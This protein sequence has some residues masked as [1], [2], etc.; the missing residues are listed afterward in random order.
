MNK[1]V[2]LSLIACAAACAG[3]TGDVTPAT[4]EQV[5]EAVAQAEFVRVVLASSLAAANLPPAFAD[6]GNAVLTEADAALDKCEEQVR[7]T[8]V[9]WVYKVCTTTVLK[10][11]RF[12][13]KQLQREAALAT[14]ST[15]SP[16]VAN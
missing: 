4:P 1:F 15:G 12:Q 13:L 14:A 3:Q 5:E 9:L 10:R 6:R 16:A 2:F 8:S 7:E 11:S